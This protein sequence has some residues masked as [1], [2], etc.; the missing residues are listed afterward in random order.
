MG[1]LNITRRNRPKLIKFNALFYTLVSQHTI[2]V[3]LARTDYLCIFV[4]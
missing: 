4:V 1:V 2:K 3:Y